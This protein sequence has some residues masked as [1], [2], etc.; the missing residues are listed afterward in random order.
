METARQ[1]V[2]HRS[3]GITHPVFASFVTPAEAHLAKEAG[4][5]AVTGSGRVGV[6]ARLEER[7]E[8]RLRIA[9]PQLHVMLDGLE[10]APHLHAHHSSAVQ[11]TLPFEDRA[12]WFHLLC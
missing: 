1:I 8:C 2:E 6:A 10:K 3:E 7:P 9:R 11:R 5:A 12:V 4:A